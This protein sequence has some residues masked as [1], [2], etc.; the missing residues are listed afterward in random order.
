MRYSIS[1]GALA[2]VLCLL[3]HTAFASEKSSSSSSSWCGHDHFAKE[4]IQSKVTA[5]QFYWDEQFGTPQSHTRKTHDEDWENIRIF[6]HTYNVLNDEEQRTCYNS[7][8]KYRVGFPSDQSV[9]CSSTVTSNCWGQCNTALVISQSRAAVVDEIVANAK[10][11]LEQALLVLSVGGSLVLGNAQ[12]CG[13]GGGVTIPSTY[14]TT[15]VS[16][17]DIV[18]FVTSRPTDEG[19][20]GWGVSCQED[21]NGRSI[22]GQINIS[23]LL[24]QSQYTPKFRAAVIVHEIF[25]VLGFSGNKFMDFRDENGNVRSQTVIPDSH[26]FKGKNYPVKK[27]ATP[28][29]IA[30]GR[31]YFDC[32]TL[33]GI[34]LEDYG[35]SGTAGSHWEQRLLLNELMT[36]AGLDNPGSGP[37]MSVFTLAAME[38][39][40]WYRVDHNFTEELEWGRGFGCSFVDDRCE[41]SWPTFEDSGVS[42]YF[43]NKKLLP[44]SYCT[45]DQRGKGFCTAA[46]YSQPLPEYYQHFSDPN[47]GGQNPLTD[48]CP[49]I[50]R[51]PDGDCTNPDNKDGVDAASTG[52]YFGE[53][54]RCFASDLTTSLFINPLSDL[55]TRCFM[56]SCI[57]GVLY[58]NV[59]KKWIKCPL[60]GGHIKRVVGYSGSITCPKASFICKANETS[61]NSDEVPEDVINA[62]PPAVFASGGILTAFVSILVVLL[63]L[64]FHRV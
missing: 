18:I 56:Y 25:H 40:G 24:L 49:Y 39:S 52:E 27:L 47:I 30:A 64:S 58:T 17:T 48:Y 43:C 34:E 11:Q 16:N 28:A 20:L 14:K 19:V 33:D 5:R 26:T 55:G 44:T 1:I 21:Q 63:S 50:V 9:L 15:G 60:D 8:D 45:F 42:G 36:G 46:V 35:S 57:N 37:V 32:D 61:S 29:V 22:A 10:T 38:D 41:E 3:L 31:K 54:S 23:P 59:G 13:S 51:N 12:K 2:I 62:A 7:A 4:A 6:F 53:M